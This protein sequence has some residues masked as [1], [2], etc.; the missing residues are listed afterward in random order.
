MFVL[1]VVI[2]SLN[3]YVCLSSVL[4]V[5]N[6]NGHNPYITYEYT[7]VRDPLNPVSQPPVYTGSNGGS[8]HQVSV[9]VSNVSSHNGSKYDEAAPEP[10]RKQDNAQDTGTGLKPGQETN[11]VFEDSAGIDCEQD[12]PTP[13]LYQGMHQIK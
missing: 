11:E 4:K 12:A 1:I 10:Q 13:P 8:S 2:Y 3:C 5:W 6:Q 7:V 9:E